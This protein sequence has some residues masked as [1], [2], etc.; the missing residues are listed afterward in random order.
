MLKANLR[1]FGPAADMIEK[2]E[3]AI[4]DMATN[5]DIGLHKKDWDTV[6]RPG[7]A[8]AMSMLF[9]LDEDQNN[10]CPSCKT[11]CPGSTTT[12]TQWYVLCCNDYI[13][14]YRFK[15]TNRL[16]LFA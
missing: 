16:L 15:L 8:V 6:F 12:A 11:V 5:R 2:G 13:R 14:H 10:T 9:T 7:Q 4:F 3:F 1:N